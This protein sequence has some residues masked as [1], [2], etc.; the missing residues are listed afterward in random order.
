MTVLD[1]DLERLEE[2]LLSYTWEQVNKLQT[3]LMLVRDAFLY[4]LDGQWEE[5][6]MMRGPMFYALHG[7]ALKMYTLF[8]TSQ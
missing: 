3:N 1:K 6:L 5:Q 8:P 7:T 4:P 2:I